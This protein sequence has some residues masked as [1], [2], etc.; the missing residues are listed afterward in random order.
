VYGGRLYGSVLVSHTHIH[1]MVD[2]SRDELL[3]HAGNSRRLKLERQWQERNEYRARRREFVWSSRVE[4]I[5]VDL[6]LYY[7]RRLQY[8]Y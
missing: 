5:R 6:L 4:S 8:Y 1:K 2:H 3:A 7:T